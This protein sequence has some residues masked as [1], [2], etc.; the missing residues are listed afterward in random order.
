ME[1]YTTSE[2]LVHCSNCGDFLGEEGGF[3]RECSCEVYAFCALVYKRQAENKHLFEAV[4]WVST[5]VI[6][7]PIAALIGALFSLESQ[8]LMLILEF[9]LGALVAIPIAFSFQKYIRNHFY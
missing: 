2:G 3:I 9:V 6:S 8:Y 4:Y 5:Y 1:T 7:F